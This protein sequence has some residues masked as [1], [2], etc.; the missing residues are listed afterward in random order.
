M[1]KIKDYYYKKAKEENYAARSVYK[2]QEIDKKYHLI[3]PGLKVIDI[4]CSP[5]SWSQLILKKIKNGLLI[6]IDISQRPAIKD[7][8]FRFINKDILKMD[9]DSIKSIT[10]TVDL[11]LS[12]ATPKTTGDKFSDSQ[13]SLRIVERVFDIAN[14]I[15]VPGGNVVAKV[16]Q[17]ED[18]DQFINDKIKTRY[19]KI[20]RYKPKSSRKES[21]EIY[22]I[23]LNKRDTRSEE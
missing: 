20:A 11:I 4:G 10:T 22:I 23:A 15:L 19:A 17:G 18:L 14:E 6:G 3:K 21:R 8:R 9:I 1:K 13:K 2:L 12:D 16:F 7:Y 5:G